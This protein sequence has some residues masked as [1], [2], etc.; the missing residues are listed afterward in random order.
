VASVEGLRG[1]AVPLEL[2]ARD[3]AGCA[4]TNFLASAP[5]RQRRGGGERVCACVRAFARLV[6]CV[7]A[8]VRVCVCACV[9]V[10]CV[11]CV[12][13][14]VVARRDLPPRDLDHENAAYRRQ[15]VETHCGTPW[16][17]VTPIPAAVGSQ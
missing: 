4:A 16:Q 6:M 1:D 9:R 2:E 10:V 11:Y 17:P 7:R 13:V 5:V 12:P 8:C 15:A 14:S 3:R